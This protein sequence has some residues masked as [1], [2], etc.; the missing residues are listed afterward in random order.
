MNRGRIA[1]WL[2]KGVKPTAAVR[3]AIEENNFT[4]MKS[5]AFCSGVEYGFDPSQKKDDALT[6]ALNTIEKH[7]ELETAPV[8]LYKSALQEAN[9]IDCCISREETICPAETGAR[10]SILCGLCNLSYVYDTG[11]DWD[12]VNCTFA[13]GTGDP[14]WLKR[15][16]YRSQWEIKL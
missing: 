14:N 16:V 10:S 4:R 11:F 15:A 6:T 8:Q 3:K 13:N 5:V 9:F 7:F 12:P 1:V 2:G